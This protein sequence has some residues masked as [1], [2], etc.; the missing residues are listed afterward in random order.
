MIHILHCYHVQNGVCLLPL[1]LTLRGTSGGNC[2]KNPTAF[3]FVPYLL[4][5][6]YS[7]V[8]F[9][10]PLCRYCISTDTAVSTTDR[11]T[12]FTEKDS[13]LLFCFLTF[14]SIKKIHRFAFFSPA[15]IKIATAASAALHNAS[16]YMI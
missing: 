10:L 1:K 2:R 14:V 12:G 4:F 9:T 15:N 3:P 7:A 13:C 5:F 16:K 6:V 11:H 8:S